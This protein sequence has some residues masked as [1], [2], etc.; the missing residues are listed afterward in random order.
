MFLYLKKLTQT[1]FSELA[2]VPRN[3]IENCDEYF[4]SESMLLLSP[5]LQIFS[6]KELLAF[7]LRKEYE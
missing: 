1:I 3:L 2:N 6:G 5:I 4:G 7:Q